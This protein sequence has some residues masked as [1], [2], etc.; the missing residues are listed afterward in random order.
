LYPETVPY[1][2]AKVEAARTAAMLRSWWHWGEVCV[3][4]LRPGSVR[5][6]SARDGTHRLQLQTNAQL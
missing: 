6:D 1:G 5:T 2:R 4:R 3:L